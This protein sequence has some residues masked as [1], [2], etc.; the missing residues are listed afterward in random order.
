MSR[1]VAHDQPGKSLHQ[2]NDESVRFHA[3]SNGEWTLHVR[4][5]LE[6]L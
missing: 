3:T 5:I 2:F 4:S 6:L 1:T